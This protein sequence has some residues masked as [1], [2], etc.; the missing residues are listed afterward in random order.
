VPSV[1][2]IKE[3]IITADIKKHLLAYPGIKSLHFSA[4]TENGIVTLTGNI[5]SRWYSRKARRVKSVDN[6]LPVVLPAP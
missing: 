3:S 4:T 1:K 2:Y 6:K 5:K